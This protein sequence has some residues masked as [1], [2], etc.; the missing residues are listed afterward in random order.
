M[1]RSIK[2]NICQLH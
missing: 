2:K 1:T